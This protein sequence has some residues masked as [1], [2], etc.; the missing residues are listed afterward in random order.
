MYIPYCKRSFEEVRKAFT[1][2]VQGLDYIHSMGLI[3]LDIKFDNV[4]INEEDCVKISDFGL[5][6]NKKNLTANNLG[7]TAG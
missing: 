4:L 2:I 6:K 1:Q 3:H 7:Y 5:T